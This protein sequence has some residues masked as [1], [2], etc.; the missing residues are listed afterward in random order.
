ML[1][2]D[3]VLPERRDGER[4]AD[5]TGQITRTVDATVGGRISELLLGGLGIPAG[6]GLTAAVNRSA[7][8]RFQ[9]HEV[10]R[11]SVHVLALGRA[12]WGARCC[13]STP[14]LP[15]PPAST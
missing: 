7:G 13:G 6:V 1:A 4:L 8:V 14:S 5:I 11:S 12:P 15:A 10:F 3:L 9:F 2:G